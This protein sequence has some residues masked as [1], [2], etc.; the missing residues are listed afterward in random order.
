MG[1]SAER[2]QPCRRKSLRQPTAHNR[3]CQAYSSGS[4]S[5]TCA[6][7]TVYTDAV[8]A[9]VHNH[10]LLLLHST[11]DPGLNRTLLSLVEITTAI[12]PK[13]KT[14]ET[15]GSAA[16]RG[17][18]SAPQTALRIVFRGSNGRPPSR[19]CQQPRQRRLDDCAARA[20]LR[21]Q[22]SLVWRL[23]RAVICF[24]ALHSRRIFKG[25]QRCYRP[26]CPDHDRGG[27]RRRH[28]RYISET[29]QRW[30]GYRSSRRL[31]QPG[32][33]ISDTASCSQ[34]RKCSC[35]EPGRRALNTR[36]E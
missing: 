11:G 30:T 33:R 19:T 13:Q 21:Q 12:R 8:A 23:L 27:R 1:Y 6:S 25:G 5:L 32:Q 22:L 28:R 7:S 10:T 36:H 18:S 4:S 29:R 20:G 15:S 9:L 24:L 2:I 34:S 35:V 14:A 26:A 16:E 17:S 31:S 3:I